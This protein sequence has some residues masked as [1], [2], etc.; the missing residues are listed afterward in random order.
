VP[1]PFYNEQAV[2]VDGETLRLVINFRTI[3]ATEQLLGRGYDEIL[4]ELQRPNCPI[5]VTGKVVWGFLREH[6]PEITLDETAS[7]LFGEN[8]LKVG[9]AISELLQSAFP[10]AENAKGQNPPK[11]RGTSKASSNGGARRG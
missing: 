8:A 10:A 5:G 7:L 6:H 2:V 11:P 1:K 3:D 9:L 4:D